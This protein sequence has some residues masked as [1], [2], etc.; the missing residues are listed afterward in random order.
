[1]N[2]KKHAK[3]INFASAGVHWAAFPVPTRDIL[4]L[5]YASG[6]ICRSN[7]IRLVFILV[8]ESFNANVVGNRRELQTFAAAHSIAQH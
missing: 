7:F 8:I 5:G 1:M 2:V 6:W 4:E 3:R